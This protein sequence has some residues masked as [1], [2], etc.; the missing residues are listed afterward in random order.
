MMPWWWTLRHHL[1]ISSGGK[2]RFSNPNCKSDCTKRVT[3]KIDIEYDDTI[4][5][6]NKQSQNAAY[7]EHV[8]PQG[9]AKWQL[10]RERHE[11]LRVV[12]LKL[13]LNSEA[14]ELNS[15]IPA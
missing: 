5:S 8:N 10:F 2:T 4:A 7:L 13:G 14:K 12:K 3:E 1:T 15:R 9:I 11:W 6:D